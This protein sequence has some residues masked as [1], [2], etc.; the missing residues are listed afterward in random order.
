MKDKHSRLLLGGKP[1]FLLGFAGLA[2]GLYLI[3]T[4]ALIAADGIQYIRRAQ[5]FATDTDGVIRVSGFGYPFLIFVIHSLF[6]HDST[7]AIGWAYAAQGTALVCRLGACFLLYGMARRWIGP[8][9]S[10]MAVLALLLLPY[11]ARFGADGMR[12]WPYLLFLIAAMGALLAGCGR[13]RL[14]WFVLAGCLSGMGYL[15]RVEGAQVVLLGLIALGVEWFVRSTQ[16]PR[17]R[18]MV[19]GALMLVGFFV[20]GGWQ[21]AIQ[22]RVL[23]EKL[24]FGEPNAKVGADSPRSVRWPEPAPLLAKMGPPPQW[25]FTAFVR[26]PWMLLKQTAECMSPHVMVV[27]LIGLA[28]AWRRMRDRLP[29]RFW[30]GLWGG[31]QILMLIYLYST[32]GY[33][34]RRHVLPIVVALCLFVPE[35]LEI[36]ARRICRK[37]GTESDPAGVIR[38]AWILLGVGMAINLPKLATPLRKDKRDYRQAS[39]WLA[40]HTLSDTYLL[41]DDP[42]IGFYSDRPYFLNQDLTKIPLRSKFWATIRQETALEENA[43]KGVFLQK[44]FSCGPENAGGVAVFAIHRSDMKARWPMDDAE[45]STL[46]RDT[47]NLQWQGRAQRNTVGMTTEGKFHKALHFDGTTDSVTVR[48]RPFSGFDAWTIAAWVKCEDA[49]NPTLISFGGL[50]PSVRFQNN[51]KGHPILQM[52]KDNFRYFSASAWETLHDGQWHHVAITM[53]GANPTS[54]QSSAMYLDGKAVESVLT[55][56]K[57]PQTRK[58]KLILGDTGSTDNYHFSGALDEVWLYNRALTAAEIEQWY[59]M[60]K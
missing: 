15:I 51:G 27:G 10:F 7:T 9:R 33:M 54:I 59:L 6:L 11:P 36:L 2:V 52:G 5:Q 47:R 32:Y 22:G 26:T 44:V 18:I 42:R 14:G 13:K 37:P 38:T 40:K 55:E 25:D 3:G 4:T 29:A 20:G 43:K 46:V 19:A 41:V 17:R 39:Q 57:G 58:G 56:D 8:A 49:P 48:T 24:R 34:S 28:A 35:G 23:P 12:D 60:G 21:M 50:Y 1:L 45:T 31:F 16:Q 30:I 53:P